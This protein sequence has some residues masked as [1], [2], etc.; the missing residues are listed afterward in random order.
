MRG[1]SLIELMVVIAIVALLAAV[2]VPTYKDYTIKAK[3]SRAFTVLQVF[4]EKAEIY[5]T[6]RGSF[7]NSVSDLGYSNGGSVNP[8]NGYG[9]AALNTADVYEAGLFNGTCSGSLGPCVWVMLDTYLIGAAAPGILGLILTTSNNS[10]LS[11]QCYTR[12][13][14]NTIPAKYLPTGCMQL[15]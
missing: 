3:V 6:T 4:K 15:P 10:V 2:A 14:V 7:P 9:T 12:T 5:F 11:W 13:A 8:S 1:F